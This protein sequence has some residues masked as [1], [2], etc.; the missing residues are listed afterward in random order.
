MHRLHHSSERDDRDTNFGTIF[1]VWDRALRTYRPS[2]SGLA[3]VAGL[4]GRTAG[5]PPSLRDLLTEP[6]RRAAA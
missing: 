2:A 4:P 1:A 6:L 5:A 3:F